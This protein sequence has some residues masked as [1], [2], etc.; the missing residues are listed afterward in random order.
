[1]YCAC[2][3]SKAA[4]GVPIAGADPICNRISK[5]LVDSCST[6]FIVLCC[7][8]LQLQVIVCSDQMTKIFGGIGSAIYS[9]S[10]SGSHYLAINIALVKLCVHI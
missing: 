3:F 4:E 2:L 7:T 6:S 10:S 1:M 8:K 9:R 5:H